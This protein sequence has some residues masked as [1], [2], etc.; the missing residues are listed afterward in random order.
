MKWYEV[1]PLR[2]ELEKRLL[3]QHHPGF[4]LIKENGRWRVEIKIRT[5]KRLYHLK[6]IFPDRFPNS[7]MTVHIEN[8]K[9]RDCPP[10]YFSREGGLCIY[11]HSNYGPETTAKVYLDWS[12]QWLKCYEHWQDT[13]IWPKNNGR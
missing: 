8:P 11:G 4:R 6:G 10:H 7:P 3:R 1:N 13:G 2:L 9:I 5:P 12:K